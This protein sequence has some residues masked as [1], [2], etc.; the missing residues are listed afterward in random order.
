MLLESLFALI[1]KA[2]VTGVVAGTVI[3]Q[4]CLNWD[5]IV[6]FMHEHTSLKE[7]DVNNVGFSLQQ[8]LT[9]GEYKTVYGI[10]NTRSQKVLAAESVCSEDV[11]TQVASAHKDNPLVI[12]S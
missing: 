5:R 1:M 12:F 8:K 3:A 10:F 2:A 11:D 7:A 9:S 6:A 4:I